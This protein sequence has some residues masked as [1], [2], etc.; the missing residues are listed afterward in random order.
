MKNEAELKDH[1]RNLN[2]GHILGGGDADEVAGGSHKHADVAQPVDFEGVVEVVGG[3]GEVDSEHPVAR[4]NDE[5]IHPRL[6]WI[7][8][9]G[10]QIVGDVYSHA[11]VR[12]GG[13]VVD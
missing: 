13:V 3:V 8:R 2:G 1:W 4:G 5:I 6:Q 10:V 12:N 11:D 9:S 7:I